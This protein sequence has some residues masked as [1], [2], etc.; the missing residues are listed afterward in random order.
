MTR[1]EQETVFRFDATPGGMASVFTASPAVSRRLRLRYGLIPKK[2]SKTKGSESGWFF[3]IPRAAFRWRI[4][5]TPRRRSSQKPPY[6]GG[7]PR[8]TG[9]SGG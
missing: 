5:M 7:V 6:F 2:I 9:A 4:Q 8:A 1:D 3:E